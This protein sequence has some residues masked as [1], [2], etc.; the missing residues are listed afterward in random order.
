[1]LAHT[2]NMHVCACVLQ[3]HE[4]AAKL[5]S[6]K[7]QLD[8]TSEARADAEAE[9]AALQASLLQQTAIAEAAQGQLAAAAITQQ[10]QALL[11]P[12]D[13]AAQPAAAGQ[14]PADTAALC[15]D[16]AHVMQRQL[17]A[18]P[19]PAADPKAQ[20]IQELRAALAAALAD[21][22]DAARD[23]LPDIRRPAQ[24]SALPVAPGSSAVATLAE[25]PKVQRLQEVVGALMSAA[26]QMRPDRAADSAT[27]QHPA[28]AS[29]SAGSANSGSSSTTADPKQQR[30]QELRAALSDA[31]KEQDELRQQLQDRAAPW[32]SAN[33]TLVQAEQQ[34]Q[35][36]QQQLV[37]AQVGGVCK[38]LGCAAPSITHC[39]R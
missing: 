2:A 27:G 5:A 20:R 34:L 22:G 32:T 31:L 35:E 29:S 6:A 11:V 12:Q 17:A 28:P 36:A 8:L 18:S 30:I 24:Q 33:N 3:V 14:Q 16:L 7:V 21:A 37:A 26:A 19:V 13:A 25:D 23:V 10:V 15:A 1:M 38:A 9:V 39:S 4:L